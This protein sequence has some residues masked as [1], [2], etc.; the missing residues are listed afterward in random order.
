MKE[1]HGEGSAVH[2]G[3]ESCGVAREGGAEALTGVRAGWVLSRTTGW[4]VYLSSQYRASLS[5]FRCRLIA[6][7]LAY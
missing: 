5:V 2:T 1:L 4:L 7:L 3:P 6:G